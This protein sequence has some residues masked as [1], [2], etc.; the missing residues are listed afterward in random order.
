MVP[1]WRN[2]GKLPVEPELNIKPAGRPIGNFSLN[3]SYF[4][5]FLILF[6]FFRE[7]DKSLYFD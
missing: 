6:H 1:Y 2:H 4:I 3:I 7:H 5:D